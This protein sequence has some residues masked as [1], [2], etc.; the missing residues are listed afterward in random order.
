MK[1]NCEIRKP[2]PPPPPPSQKEVLAEPQPRPAFGATHAEPPVSLHLSP[3]ESVSSTPAAWVSEGVQ[4]ISTPGY[5][6]TSTPASPLDPKQPA[7]QSCRETLNSHQRGQEGRVLRL[8]GGSFKIYVDRPDLLGD[9]ARGSPPPEGGAR[10][11]VPLSVT[12]PL[13]VESEV[14][15]FAVAVAAFH[16]S[17]AAPAD[18]SSEEDIPIVKDERVL[19]DD[20]KFNFEIETGNGIR[21]SQ[22]GS[23]DGVD[24]AVNHAG[25][26]SYTAPDGT[27][28]ELKFVA[29]ENGFQPQSA[30]LPVAPE[31]PHPIP[32][33][34]LDQIAFAALQDAK[35]S[36]EEEEED[37][38]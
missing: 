2:Q 30:L 22:G 10:Q 38:D 3:T 26:Y 13:Q 6:V 11:G 1:L 20:G 4:A 36:E 23:P 34:V 35:E 21:M 16:L 37:D 27:L 28:V 25:Q 24:G 8:T 18:L 12:S 9:R 31:F 32:Q 14:F 7:T 19:E 29:N 33:F 5:G 17:L 15:L